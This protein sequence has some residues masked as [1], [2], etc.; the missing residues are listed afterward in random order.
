M[1]TGD[2]PEHDNDIDP[3]HNGLDDGRRR[4][5]MVF[6]VWSAFAALEAGKQFVGYRLRGM[7]IG[8]AEVLIQNVPWWYTWGLLTPVVAFLARRFRLDAPPKRGR[9]IAIHLP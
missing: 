9:A 5:L 1:A 2:E 8:I 6:G 3:G 7:P 4:R